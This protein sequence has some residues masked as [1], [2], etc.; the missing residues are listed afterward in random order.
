MQRLITT[1]LIVIIV[2]LVAWLQWPADHDERAVAP[3]RV[4]PVP[5]QATLQLPGRTFTL[6]GAVVRIGDYELASNQQR[7]ASVW[8]RLANM[9]PQ[10]AVDN[11]QP[12]VL[13]SY[14]IDGDS[15]LTLSDGR[16]LQWGEAEGL[17]WWMFDGRAVAFPARTGRRLVSELTQVAVPRLLL[18]ADFTEFSVDGLV[19]DSWR[20]PLAIAESPG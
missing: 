5:T 1:L 6:D 14:G 17:S 9:T 4:G 18:D 3:L 8:N 12:E 15:R 16:T 2:A 10:A 11:L 7:L 13:A 20:T 19:V